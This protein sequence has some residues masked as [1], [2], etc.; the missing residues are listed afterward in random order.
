[1]EILGHVV[2][3]EEVRTEERKI[4]AIANAQRPKSKKELRSFF[5][6]AS[7]YRRGL[8]GFAHIASPLYGLVSPVKRLGWNGAAEEA[9]VTLKNA[10]K[11]PPVLLLRD[12]E[13]PFIVHTDTSKAA[14]R[15]VFVQKDE[16]GRE[17]LTQFASRTKEV[18]RK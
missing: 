4:R 17:H 15:A 12:I 10:M 14:V 2:S 5:G 1:M 11:T 13:K 6:M 8:Q 18:E 16:D 9:F 7:Y 3:D